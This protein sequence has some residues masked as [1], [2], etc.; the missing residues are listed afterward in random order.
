MIRGLD[1]YTAKAVFSLMFFV[2]IK[3][4][5]VLHVLSLQYWSFKPPS[6]LY[7]NI[8]NGSPRNELKLPLYGGSNCC[9]GP[10]FGQSFKNARAAFKTI[11]NLLGS[12]LGIS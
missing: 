3:A 11:F 9:I 10:Y 8:Q 5:R 7:R 1:L 2:T 4:D 6:D 12:L